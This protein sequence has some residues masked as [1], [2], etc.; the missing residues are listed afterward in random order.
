VVTVPGGRTRAL[1]PVLCSSEDNSLMPKA[2]KKEK[3]PYSHTAL[4]LTVSG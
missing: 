4:S 1:F 3:N 2:E